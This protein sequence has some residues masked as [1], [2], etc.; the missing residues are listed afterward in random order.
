MAKAKLKK[1]PTS[2]VTFLLDRSGSMRSCLDAT[3]E[4]VNGY[5]AGLKAEKDA[6]ISLTL[7]QFDSVSLD[8]Y[9]VNMPV[10]EVLDLT[11]ETYSPRGGTPLIDAAVKTIRAMEV[12]LEACDDNPKVILCI[13]TDGQENE[14]RQHTWEELRS[15]ITAK[16]SEGWQFNFMGAGIEGYDQASRMGIAASGTMSYNSA[17]IGAAKSAFTAS[18]QNAASYSAGRSANTSYT[19]D[20][21]TLS[22]DKHYQNWVPAQATQSPIAR[23]LDLTIDDKAK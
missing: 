1:K 8:K 11:R 22:G 10:S 16:T 21:R 19:V 20:Q 9:C 3:I 23:P 5:I 12:A 17:D 7:L 18:A 14:S 4:A 6:A 2:R 13:Q 15:L